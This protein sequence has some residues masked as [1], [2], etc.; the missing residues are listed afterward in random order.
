MTTDKSKSSGSGTVPPAYP[1]PAVQLATKVLVTVLV[2][3]A[4]H[5]A[6]KIR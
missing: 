6:T 2:T 5:H 1:S 3:A 4:N